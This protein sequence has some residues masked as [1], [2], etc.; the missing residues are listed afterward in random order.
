MLGAVLALRGCLNAAFGV[1]L[2]AGH[3]S[4]TRVFEA[5]SL[6]AIADG[7]LGLIAVGSIVLLTPSGLLRVL[8]AITAVDAIGRIGIGIVVLALPGLPHLPMAVVPFFAAIGAAVA[9]LG[10]IGLTA[11]VVARA[12]TRRDWSMNAEALFD[13][14]AGAALVSLIIGFL[15]F[16]N[17]PATLETLRTVAAAATGILAL[18]FLTA[19][20][21]ALVHRRTS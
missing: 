17:P 12:R 3:P 10:A 16:T 2:L 4:W 11:W 7:A 13:P 6:Y 21:G 5:G 8:A 20:L 1:W 19:S 14:L 9:G 15:L 18:V